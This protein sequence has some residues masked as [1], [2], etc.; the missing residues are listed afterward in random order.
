M[1]VGGK[2]WNIGAADLIAV[3]DRFDVRK[4]RA[5]LARLAAA[6][7]RWPQFA[8]RAQVPRGEVDRI[9]AY[10]PGWVNEETPI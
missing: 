6:V 1:L 10:H 5:L 9:A 4:P 3:A 7:R 8:G 2:A